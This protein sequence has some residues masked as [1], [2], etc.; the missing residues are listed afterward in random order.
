MRLPRQIAKFIADVAGRRTR[1]LGSFSK[2]RRIMRA[3]SLGRS[4]RRS[5]TGGAVSRRIAEINPA[6]ESLS[7][8][9]RPVAISWSTTPSEKMSVRGSSGRPEACSGDM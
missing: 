3:R 9:R 6:E 5:V 4:G 8:G 2:Q 1:C 7:K